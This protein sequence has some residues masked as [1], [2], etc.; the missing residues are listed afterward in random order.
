MTNHEIDKHAET[1]LIAVN[2]AAQPQNRADEELI[3]SVVC[4]VANF[5]KNINDIAEAARDA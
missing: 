1:I 2:N 3:E 5:L 4:L